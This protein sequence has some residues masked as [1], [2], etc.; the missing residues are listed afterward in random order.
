MP[1]RTPSEIYKKANKD[2]TSLI[3]EGAR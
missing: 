1:K 3:K 2:F